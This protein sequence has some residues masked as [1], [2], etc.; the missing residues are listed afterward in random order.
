MKIILCIVVF[1]H[2]VFIGVNAVLF[3]L[4]LC[5]KDKQKKMLR[6]M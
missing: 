5:S 6:A 3:I 2:A 4:K 1:Y